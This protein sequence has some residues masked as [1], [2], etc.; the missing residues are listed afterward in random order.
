VKYEVI[1][2]GVDGGGGGDASARQAESGA[3]GVAQAFG[4]GLEKKVEEV[5]A[6]AEDAAQ[7]FWKGEH[8][9]PVRDFVADGGGD[10]SA[11]LA[12]AA[13]VAGGAEV[14]GLAG[15]GEELFVAALGAMEA[16]EAR[17]EIAAPKEGA[18]GGDG[19]GAQRSHGAAVVL[20]V[21]GDEIVPG[22]VDDL[23][24]GRGARAARAVNRGHKG[25][26][27]EHSSGQRG[28]DA[29]TEE[30]PLTA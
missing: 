1:A 10:P 9:L 24:E 11:G 15:E 20:F 19:I 27:W 17:G 6:L 5:P 13:L 18:D 25:C 4:R 2:E 23:P 26:S 3:E 21:A 29:G 14:A 8:I 30:M 28:P 22:V 7:H 12:D 16:S